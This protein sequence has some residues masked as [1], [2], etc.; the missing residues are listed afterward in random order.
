[1]RLTN[2]TATELPTINAYRVVE[3]TDIVR[4]R[5]AIAQ[6]LIGQRA[7]AAGDAGLQVSSVSGALYYADDDNLW[8][9]S[10]GT[11]LPQDA[12]AAQ[13]AAQQWLG[14]SRK[15]FAG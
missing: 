14:L 11:G 15:R 8:S 9:N 12:D 5:E 4:A 6:A 1:M 2:A 13:Q 3:A 7:T 10:G